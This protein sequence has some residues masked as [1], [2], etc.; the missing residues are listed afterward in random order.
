MVDSVE[1]LR[2][3]RRLCLVKNQQFEHPLRTIPSREI[4]RY[5][6]A[7]AMKRRA[8]MPRSR[9]EFSLIVARCV[10]SAGA[11]SGGGRVLFKIPTWTIRVLNTRFSL[12]VHARARSM[13]LL[14]CYRWLVD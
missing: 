8:A 6:R 11:R 12:R 14:K 7:L 5:N 1:L 9:Q 10:W 2:P 13:D 4:D 3:P